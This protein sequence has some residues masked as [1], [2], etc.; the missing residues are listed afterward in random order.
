MIVNVMESIA[1]KCN[2]TDLEKKILIQKF[3]R[4]FSKEEQERI[5]KLS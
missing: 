4:N 2:L 1:K 5:D 3:P